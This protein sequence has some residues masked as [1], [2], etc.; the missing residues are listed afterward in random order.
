MAARSGPLPGEAGKVVTLSIFEEKGDR[1]LEEINDV[2][3]GRETGFYELHS[4]A[5]SADA[6]FGRWGGAGPCWL[7]VETQARGRSP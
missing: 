5:L 4:P 1:H 6:A 2:F 7:A 3:V